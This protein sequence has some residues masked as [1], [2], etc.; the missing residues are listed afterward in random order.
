MVSYAFVYMFAQ[1]T[2]VAYSSIKQNLKLMDDLSE[3][4]KE[5]P[6]TPGIKKP[7]AA[8]PKQ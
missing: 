5:K 7:E 3:I 4:V 2:I 6:Q 1:F 8:T